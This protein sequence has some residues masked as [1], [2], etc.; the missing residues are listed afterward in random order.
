MRAKIVK[1]LSGIFFAVV[2]LFG[3]AVIILP[4]IVSTDAIRIRLAQDLSVWTGYNVQLRDPPRL[5]LFPYP[6]A[7]LSGVTLTQK[8]DDNAPLMEA[9]SIEVDLSLIDLLWKRV[10]F[11]ETRIIRPQFVIEKPVKTIADFFDTLSQSQGALGLT[12]RSARE[13]VMH[14]PDQPDVE[15]LLRQPF[16]RVVIKNGVL[17]YRDSVSD[18]AEKITGLN[19]TM[20]WPESTRAA[21][22]RANAHWRGELTELII[23]ADQALLL[24][25]GG[26]SP[27]KISMNSLRGGITF[28]GQAQLSEYYVVDG[29]VSVRSPGWDQTLAWIGGREFFGHKFKIPIVWES[30]FLAQP[31]CIQMNN[32]TFTMGAANARGALEFNFQNSVPIIIG[33]LAFDNLDLSLLEST[34]LSVEEKNKFFDT[35]IF[36]RIGLD[37][38]LSAPRAKVGNVELTNLA[39]AIQLKNGRGIFD[40]GNANLFGG[41]IQSNIQ[42]IPNDKKV[43]IEGRTSGTSIDTKAVSDTLG[44]IPFVQAKTNFIMT[45]QVLAGRWS[46]ILA[47]MQGQLTLNM[48]TG[49]LIGYDLD[50][51][52][53][54]LLKNEKFLLV[55]DGGVSTVFDRLDVKAKF[56]S[57]A[58]TTLTLSM[59]TTNWNLFIQKPTT[60]SVAKSKQNKQILR[61]ELQ[62]NNRSETVCKDI[63]C[64][65]N[66]LV[67]SLAFSLDPT[68][69]ALGNFFVKKN[70][71]EN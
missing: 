55:N 23:N 6:K 48:S 27:L 51:L 67:W 16:G 38:R 56:A 54:K 7:F 5:D 47:K 40:L 39:A 9:E 44:F 35:T 26:K 11:S 46:E 68:E 33:S 65:T 13:V 29:K 18:V 36:N 25:A 45:T 53:K 8:I 58:I 42:I 69:Q 14:N 43:R 57:D 24:L 12:I 20:D 62:S 50:N 30:H 37:V 21:R 4:Y 28:V 66:S 60:L 61:A 64:L 52:Q 2:F 49:R 31:T 15:H 3:A 63:Q 71:H 34:L 17:V 19:A 22:F 70:I 10:S 32:V 41:S 1:F 59:D